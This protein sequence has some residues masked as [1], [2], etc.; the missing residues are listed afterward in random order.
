MAPGCRPVA[1]GVLSLLVIASNRRFAEMALVGVLVVSLSV[2][3]AGPSSFDRRSDDGRAAGPEDTADVS[4]LPVI[5]DAPSV[6][7]LTAEALPD[8]LE[9]PDSTRL[10]SLAGAS[11]ERGRFE[12][13]EHVRGIYLN[14]WASG[15][16]NRTAALLELA[17]RTE[18]NAFVIDIKDAS[19]YVSHRTEVP[20]AHEVGA[21]EEVRIRDLAGLLSRLDAAGIYP[22]ARIVIV[23]DPLLSAGRPDL[24]VQDTAG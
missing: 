17:A 21:T 19:G 10:D 1:E 20:L 7:T 6:E 22:I 16:T 2:C 24:A 5:P 11:V 15:S 8:T 4:T 12:R 3:K 18:V 14:A 9:L 23:K 13:P